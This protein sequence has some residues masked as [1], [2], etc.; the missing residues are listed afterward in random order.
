MAG[1]FKIVKYLLELT[2]KEQ[3]NWIEDDGNTPLHLACAL[4]H[5][6]IVK[7][8]LEKG[9]SKEIENGYSQIPWDMARKAEI[10]ELTRVPSLDREQ[11]IVLE[12]HMNYWDVCEMGEYE[13]LQK[14][15][16]HLPIHEINLQGAWART[17][18]HYCAIM[19]QV[20]HCNLLIQNGAMV[21]LF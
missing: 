9:A 18:L 12:K 21:K 7:L 20:E 13:I 17:P 11:L 10:K 14:I 4:G 16:K 8:L 15:L 3:L 19:G 1:Q 2:D 6:E 5:T